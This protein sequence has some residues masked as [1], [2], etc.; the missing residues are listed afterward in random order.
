M[1]VS[2]QVM[3]R[4]ADTTASLAMQP[5]DNIYYDDKKFLRIEVVDTGYGMAKVTIPS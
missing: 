4:G 5:P 2:A 3:N 1:T